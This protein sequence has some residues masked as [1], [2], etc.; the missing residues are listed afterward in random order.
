MNTHEKPPR[1][2]AYADPHYLG[3]RYA[4][5]AGKSPRFVARQPDPRVIAAMVLERV[6][7]DSESAATALP[8]IFRRFRPIEERYRKLAT[9]LVYTTLR[10][11]K[12][13]TTQLSAHAAGSLPNDSA[14][15]AHLL[16]AAT[17]ILYMDHDHC[18][19]P[20]AVDVAVSQ[21]EVLRGPRMAGIANGILSRVLASQVPIDRDTSAR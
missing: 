17:E 19:G 7:V 20:A 9:E 2:D 8:A 4:S 10:M 11:Q 6:L 13:V 3:E 14:L 18:S 1:T 21:V 16:V 5:R 12:A 15:L